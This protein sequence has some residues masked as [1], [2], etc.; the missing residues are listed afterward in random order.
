LVISDSAR[1]ISE[2]AGA[3]ILRVTGLFTMGKTPGAEY[4][5]SGSAVPPVPEAETLPVWLL[6]F[7]QPATIN[8][9]TK[10]KQITNVENFFI[11]FILIILSVVAIPIPR[12][13]ITHYGGKFLPFTSDNI[14][15]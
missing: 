8:A 3:K 2:D 1:G 5:D 11:S 7:E 12:C 9:S 10:T 14:H 4:R 15:D 13:V 6:F